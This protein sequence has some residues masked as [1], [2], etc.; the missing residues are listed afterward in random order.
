[1]FTNN[2][3]H[4]VCKTDPNFNRRTI[5][6]IPYKP[7][8]NRTSDSQYQDLLRKILETGKSSSVIQGED[9]IR[10]VG[11]QLRYDMSN[12]FPLITERDMSGKFLTAALGEHI[13]FLNGAQT[14]EE[15]VKFGCK[16][17][18]RWTTKEKCE[19]F[20]LE[21]G[22]LG[23]GSYGAAWAK[24]PTAEGTP[25]NQIEHLQKQIK[26]RPYLRTHI[27]T[28]WIPQ[29]TIQHEGLKRKVVV[30]PC[31][32]WVH[33]VTYP[34]DKKFAIHHFQRSGDMPV[35]VPFNMVQYAA[36]GLM[37]GHLLDWEFVEY[38]HTFSDGHIY[39]SQT[40]HVKKLIDREPRKL[41]TVSL[42]AEAVKNI[43][44]LRDFRPEHF[45]VS[46]YDPHEKMIIPT[47]V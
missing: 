47:P 36:F 44:D 18:N 26:E 7:V 37:L 3:G 8:A 9:A 29:Y 40:D 11:T 12:G 1:L 41:P 21:A 43:T 31:H 6:S 10:I 19:I 15:L 39:K 30:A 23:P 14:H 46:D 5:M 27:L 13:A 22:D 35:G 17:W 25:F 16:Y 32:G 28:P 2:I 38:V 45:V 24:F 34:K 20:G 33:V 42:D 4:V